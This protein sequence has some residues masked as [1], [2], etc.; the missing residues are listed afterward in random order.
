L[1]AV[2]GALLQRIDEKLTPA[3]E[4]TVGD[5]FQHTGAASL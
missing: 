5:E 1:V 2:F 3:A 4:Q